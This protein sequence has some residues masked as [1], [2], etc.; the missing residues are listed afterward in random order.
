MPRKKLGSILWK[1]VVVI[2]LLMGCAFVVGAAKFQF[3]AGHPE[4]K[5]KTLNA[6]GILIYPLPTPSHV[7]EMEFAFRTTDAFA[8]FHPFVMNLT[9]SLNNPSQIKQLYAV[10]VPTS[11]NSS[12]ISS[13]EGIKQFIQTSQEG[14]T[15][16]NDTDGGNFGVTARYG[17]SLSV[18]EDG[19]YTIMTLVLLS[20]GVYEKGYIHQTALPI[21]PYSSFLQASTARL[22]AQSIVFQTTTTYL[23]IGLTLVVIALTVVQLA[24]PRP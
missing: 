15:L 8:A 9:F 4:T 17:A 23:I 19:Q 5:P 11:L 16:F 10:L 1:V 12:L 20:S 21:E 14:G 3:F 6:K 22:T 24:K 13:N 7:S 2:L 18:S